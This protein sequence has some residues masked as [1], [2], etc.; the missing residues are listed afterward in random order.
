MAEVALDSRN[1]MAWILA[2]RVCPVVTSRTGAEHL[3]VVNVKHRRPNCRRVTVFT[4]VCCK[5]VLRILASRN[6][7]IVTAD[8]VTRY[9]RMVKVRGQPGYGGVAVVA[10]IATRNMRRMLAGRGHAIMT[11]TATAQYLCV[12]DSNRRYPHCHAVAI[13]TDI[14]SQH[15]GWILTR[16]GDA[17]VAVTAVSGDVGVI[18][19]GR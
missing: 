2:Y 6:G 19:I 14:G 11:R 8:A 9:V 4:S 18:K 7:S 17:I 10:I 1:K 5:S 3:C 16:R 12:V 15:M 13:L